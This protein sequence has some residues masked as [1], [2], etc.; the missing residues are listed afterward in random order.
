[1]E[2]ATFCRSALGRQIR[3]YVQNLQ[4][5]VAVITGAASGI[6]FALAQRFASAGMKLVL[7]DVEEDALSSAERLLADAGAEVLSMLTDVSVE[8]Q[9]HR[10]ADETF[11]CFGTAHIVCNN[12]GVGPGGVSWEIPTRVW[13]WVLG[14]DLWGVIYGIQA[15]VPRLVAQNEGHVVNT[16]SVGGL[17]GGPGMGPYEAAKHAVVGLSQSLEHDLRLVNSNVHASV[18]CP[19]FTRTRMNDSGRN[20]PARY[21]AAPESGLAP[22]HPLL[23]HRFAEAA[24]SGSATDPADVADLVHTAVINNRFWVLTED[25]PEQRLVPHYEG[26][27]EGTLP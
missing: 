1:M 15:F 25:H 27:L 3:G 6:G 16:A 19:S 26:M 14:V 17:I 8:D 10:L 5:K 9:V 24:A 13:E 20:W 23:R 2:I 18:V 21:G 7:A 12:A 22:G 11:R 4:N